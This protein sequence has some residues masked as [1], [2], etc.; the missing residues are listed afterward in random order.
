MK[1]NHDFVA[2]RPLAQ[3]CA[4]LIQAALPQRDLL[5]DA[6]ELARD[7]AAELAKGMLSV[8]SGDEIA[9]TCSEVSRSNTTAFIN[10]MGRE[11]AHCVIAMDGGGA[12]LFSIDHSAVH[13]LTDRAY[14]GTG[15][16]VEPLPVELPLSADLTLR[17]L[18]ATWCDALGHGLPAASTFAV[19]RRGGDL[20][21]LDPFR[22]QAD[23]VHFDLA[24]EQEGHAAWNIALS[25]SIRDLEC[26]LE[27][28]SQ[29]GDEASALSSAVDPMAEP[30]GDIVLPARAVLAETSISLARASGLA[31]GDT[32]PLA[33]AREVPLL[34]G[35]S[36]VARGSVG[37]QDD[38]VALQIS[39]KS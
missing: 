39:C 30:F 37:I 8:A 7:V 31:V 13:I 36:T 9:I 22:G 20:G 2:E 1:P 4:E 10:R 35:D 25:A 17:Q 28:H 26:L 15:E 12:L 5:A 34:I 33:I 32:I 21:R 19:A 14:G 3:H 27:C 16:V 29:A 23:C 24:V 38:C 18:E 11:M 6:A